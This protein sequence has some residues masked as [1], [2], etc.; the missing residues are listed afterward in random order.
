MLVAAGLAPT[1]FDGNRMSE[2]NR[3]RSL[4]FSS[5]RIESVLVS[6]VREMA[7]EDAIVVN[8]STTALEYRAGGDRGIILPWKSALMRQCTIAS[9][10]K[11]ALLDV[12][13]RTNLGGVALE[14]DW[15][16]H[17]NPQFPR[18][19]PLYI[20]SQDE[21]GDV[22]LDPLLAFTPQRLVSAAPRSYRV[23]LNL[24]YTPEETDCGIHTGHQ[25]LE[26]H[27]QILGAGHMQKFRENRAETL[28]EDVS[29][30]PGFTHDPFFSVENDRSFHYPWHRY[31]A[32]TDCIW[33]AIELHPL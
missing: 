33:M 16:G 12:R 2:S 24:W 11:A 14:W 32:D 1:W 4:S 19:T 21:I 15:Y 27:T 28:Y 23:K 6:D 31:Y 9:G 5:D 22:E 8:L 7:V 25:F 20:S 29:M 3:R 13:Q 17:R 18:A 26:V 10:G 30:P